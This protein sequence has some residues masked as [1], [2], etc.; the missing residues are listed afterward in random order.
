MSALTFLR[1]SPQLLEER[2]FN[3]FVK[4]VRAMKEANGNKPLHVTHPNPIAVPKP[5]PMSV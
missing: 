3:R 1:L 5:Q 4:F 2:H